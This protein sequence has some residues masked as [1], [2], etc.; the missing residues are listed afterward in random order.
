MEL[1][2]C[3]P[4]PHIWPFSGCWS[5]NPR[6]LYRE[7]KDILN[8]RTRTGT[9][10]LEED[11]ANWSCSSSGSFC[12]SG[13]SRSSSCSGSWRTA[14]S[15]PFVRTGP[16]KRLASSTSWRWWKLLESV[17]SSWMGDCL[18]TPAAAGM[19]LDTDAAYSPVYSV[20]LQRVQGW[21][22]KLQILQRRVVQLWLTH[23]DDLSSTLAEHWL[24]LLL[25]LR[26][27][28]IILKMLRLSSQVLDHVLSD[29]MDQQLHMSNCLISKVA[30]LSH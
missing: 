5:V 1:P 11:L 8:D 10:S 18:W 16:T 30:F 17:D 29:F 19:G 3:I 12:R 21:R 4:S 15:R 28:R 14:A 20:N 26:H 25:L 27:R 22:K 6:P 13:R 9:G 7:A 24:S 2:H 23:L